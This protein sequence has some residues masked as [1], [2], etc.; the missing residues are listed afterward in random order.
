M[1]EM[2]HQ[3]DL[4]TTAAHLLEQAQQVVGVAIGGGA[5]GPVRQ[6]LGADTDGGDVV[7]PIVEHVF[8]DPKRQHERCGSEGFQLAW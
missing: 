4:P 8:V 3:G 6:R 5:I 2:C 7:E 1:G